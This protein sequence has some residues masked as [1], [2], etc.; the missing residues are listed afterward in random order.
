MQEQK[1]IDLCFSI[2]LTISTPGVDR[3]GK[4]YDLTK[5]PIADK[6]E[7]IANQLRDNG[8]DTRP[9]GSSWGVL[10]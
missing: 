4:K 6:A 5:L 2:G 1:L 7:W 3:D 9:L 8:F 10:K